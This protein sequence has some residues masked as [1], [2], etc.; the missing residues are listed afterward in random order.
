MGITIVFNTE[1]GCRGQLNK[2]YISIS[3]RPGRNKG[4]GN[5]RNF[6]P[7]LTGKKLRERYLYKNTASANK[8]RIMLGMILDTRYGLNNIYH[9][10]RHTETNNCR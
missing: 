7:Y 5:K 4:D 1:N 9:N 10:R 3:N 8:M 6:C 2:I